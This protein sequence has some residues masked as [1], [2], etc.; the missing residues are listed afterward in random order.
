MKIDPEKIQEVKDGKIKPTQALGIDPKQVAALLMAGHTLYAQGQFED[1]K[2]LF[3]GLS[4]LDSRNPYVHGILGAIYQKQEK[5]DIAAARYSIALSLYPKDVNS[6][7]N[8]GEIFLKCGKFK[9]AANDFKAAIE[10]DP[11]HKSPAANRARLLVALTA[12]AFKLA[13]EKGM[14]AVFDAKDRINQQLGAA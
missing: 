10:L 8:R 11:D 14:S 12:E 13:K 4:A 2:K 9:E 6:L 5:Y 7:T 3:E 1:A